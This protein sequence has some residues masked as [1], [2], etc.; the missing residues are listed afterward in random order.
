[1][2]TFHV[3]SIQAICVPSLPYSSEGR[4]VSVTSFFN[5]FLYYNLFFYLYSTFG[6]EPH[7]EYGIDAWDE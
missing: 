4:Q 3:N 7:N 5:L 2:N 1:M 6:T